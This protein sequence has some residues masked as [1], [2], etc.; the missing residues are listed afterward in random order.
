MNTTRKL[1]AALTV[2]S[3]AGGAAWAQEATYEYPQAAT[4]TVTRA[5]VLAELQQARLDGSHLVAEGQTHASPVFIAQRSRADVRA[6]ARAA[7]G[8]TNALSAETN[9]FEVVATPAPTP[10]AAAKVAASVPSR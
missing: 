1:I 5:Q 4:S 9:A 8:E 10:T 6:E 2:F 7:R 3:A